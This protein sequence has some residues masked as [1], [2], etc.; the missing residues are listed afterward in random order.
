MNFIRSLIFNLCFYTWTIFSF[1]PAILLLLFPSKALR[2][3]SRIW[4]Y[5]VRW[6]LRWIVGIKM[7]VKGKR[8]KIPVLFA[9]NHQSALE[10]IVFQ[11][12]V[13]DVIFVLKRELF[14]LPIFGFALMKIGHIGINR[15]MGK[16]A[17]FKIREKTRERIGQGVS[18]AIFPEG[19]RRPVGKLGRIGSGIAVMQEETKMN[20]VPVKITTG[21][22]WG[23]N[24][25]I[26]KPGI[27]TI[28]F[29]QPIAHKNNNRAFLLENLKKAFEK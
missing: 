21:H 4:G 28:E 14:F 10:T 3:Y 27:A 19:T 8:P 16:K 23:K 17:I 1:G 13:G 26:K 12:Y 9:L 2:I 6:L 29:K 5:V 11:L 18:V 25:F 15:A 22:V 7:V 24:A 20:V